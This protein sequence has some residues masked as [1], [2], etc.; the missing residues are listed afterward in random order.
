MTKD[1]QQHSEVSGDKAHR[2]LR[3]RALPLHP[4]GN[5]ASSALARLAAC[6]TSRGSP[7]TPAAYAAAYAAY[8]ATYH[9]TKRVVRGLNF[10]AIRLLCVLHLV[11]SSL[12][13][14]VAARLAL[15]VAL[16]GSADVL[17]YSTT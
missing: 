4:C 6:G 14:R 1:E 8:K 11:L 17:L 7:I 2:K 16:A 10:G 13:R 5:S 15:D 3:S 9:A 12:A